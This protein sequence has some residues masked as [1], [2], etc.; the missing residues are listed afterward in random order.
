M[1]PVPCAPHV[2]FVSPGTLPRD[3]GEISALSLSGRSLR[4]P[5]S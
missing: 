1:A 4:S 2:N 3:S 5:L